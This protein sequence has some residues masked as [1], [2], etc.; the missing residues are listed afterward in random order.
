MK[1]SKIMITTLALSFI[2]ASG[3]ALNVMAAESGSQ[4]KKQVRQEN[5]VQNRNMKQ[6]GTA[7]QSG[8]MERNQTRTQS[9][10]RVNQSSN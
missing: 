1:N 10:K 8:S 5:T 4:Q 7:T 9:K 3:N 2:L 6:A